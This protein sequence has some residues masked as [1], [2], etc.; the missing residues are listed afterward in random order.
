M[1]Y[2]ALQR[3]RIRTMLHGQI[4]SDFRDVHIGHD[5]A[6]RELLGIGQGR[7]GSP[8]LCDGRCAGQHIIVL[9]R[10]LPLGGQFG[11]IGVSDGGGVGGFHIRMILLTYQLTDQWVKQQPQRR[12]AASHCQ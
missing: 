5:A 4:Y 6:Y 7:C 2:G 10:R 1:A 11:V 12:N 9:L 8:S 3:V